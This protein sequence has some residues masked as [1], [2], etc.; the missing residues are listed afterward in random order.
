LTIRAT[1]ILGLH[2]DDAEVG[3][4]SPFIAGAIDE[5]LGDH[6]DQE[7]WDKSI[8]AAKR[9]WAADPRDY[10]WREVTAEFDDAAL[11]AAFAKPSVS[12]EIRG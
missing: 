9:S 5:A 12:G 3:V 7:E 8:L 11:K 10:E 2:V 4:S 6:L 1:L